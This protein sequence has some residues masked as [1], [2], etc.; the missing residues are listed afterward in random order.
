MSARPRPQAREIPPE[1]LDALY[2]QLKRSSV[3]LDAERADLRNA[4]LELRVLRTQYQAARFAAAT[5]GDTVRK[6][7][8]A[9][10]QA[11]QEAR[12]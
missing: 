7:Q 5:N 11:E 8:K 4:L 12:R 1:R 2:S 6:M 9:L 10:R 3:L